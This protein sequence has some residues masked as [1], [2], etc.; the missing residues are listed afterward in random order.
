MIKMSRML[1]RGQEGERVRGEGAW[2]RERDAV[3]SS[4][5]GREPDGATRH[6]GEGAWKGRGADLCVGGLRACA[7][8]DGALLRHGL[9]VAL[10]RP[11]RQGAWSARG[12]QGSTQWPSSAGVDST[13]SAGGVVST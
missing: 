3:W 11:Q 6:R 8:V 1:Q 2:Q 10:H 13:W 12:Q 7:D 4:E 5:G 9:D